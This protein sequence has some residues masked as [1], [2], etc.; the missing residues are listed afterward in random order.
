[1]QGSRE[2]ISQDFY[3]F[4]AKTSSYYLLFIGEVRPRAVMM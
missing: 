1:M 3:N 4:I 2:E